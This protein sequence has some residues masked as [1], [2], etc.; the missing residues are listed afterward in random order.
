MKAGKQRGGIYVHSRGYLWLRD[1]SLSL[2]YLGEQEVLAHMG[3]QWKMA[4]ILLSSEHMG[5]HFTSIAPRGWSQKSRVPDIEVRIPEPLT[6]LQQSG[7]LYIPASTGLCCSGENAGNRVASCRSYSENY[8][9]EHQGHPD[10]KRRHK[11]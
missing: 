7:W 11:L 3:R 6:S 1:D 4:S 9:I 10:G 2:P 8:D 5:Q